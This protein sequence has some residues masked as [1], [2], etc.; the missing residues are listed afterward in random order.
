MVLIKTKETSPR[1]LLLEH[2]VYKFWMPP[3]GHQEQ[4]ENPRETAIREVREETGLD[5]S[6]LLP[7]MQ[8]IDNRASVVPLPHSMVEVRVEPHKGKPAHI[9]INQLYVISVA[10][11]F[12]VQSDASETIGAG[13]FAYDEM[14]H[15]N[16]PED[17]RVVL[18]QELRS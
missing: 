11:P 2:K 9:H 15:L 3:G 14:Q 8:V 18:E 17:V 1:A 6:G 5:I 10:E 4:D 13:W 16:I 7:P 12:E